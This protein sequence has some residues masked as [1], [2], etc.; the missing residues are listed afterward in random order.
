MSRRNRKLYWDK[1]GNKE[2]R[3]QEGKNQGEERLVN[4]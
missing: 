3:K 4:F 2:Q 1:E